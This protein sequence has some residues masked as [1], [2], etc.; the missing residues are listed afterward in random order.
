MLEIHF[1]GDGNRPSIQ[2][3]RQ[4]WPIKPP[5]TTNRTAGDPSSRNSTYQ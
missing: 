2:I 3:D 1:G 5:L 4:R